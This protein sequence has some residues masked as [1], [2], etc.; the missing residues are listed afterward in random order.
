MTSPAEHIIELQR[1][2]FADSNQPT[3]DSVEAPKPAGE[4][5][6]ALALSKAM[7]STARERLA[8]GKAFA[9]VVQVPTDKWI[10]VT[11]RLI[12]DIGGD[13]TY[14][15]CRRTPATNVED[16]HLADCLNEGRAVVGISP[17]PDSM[18]PRT[19]LALADERISLE[20][21]DEEMVVKA[22]RQRHG[23][24]SSLDGIDVTV[25]EFDELALAIQNSGD[26][27]QAVERL[28]RISESRKK[29]TAAKVLPRLEEALE[30]GKAREWALSLRD[31][32]LAYR[33]KIVGWEHL[34]RGAVFHG[35]PGT[36][37]TLLAQ[38]LGQSC[39]LPTVVTSVAEL[40]ATSNGYLEGVI[41]A[42]RK[43]FA[44]AR[45]MAPAILFLDE[46]NAMPNIDRLDGR[47]K[48]YWATLI[49]DF[50][51]L[52]DGAL[53]GREGVIVIGAT[54][55]IEDI[56]PALL[57]PGRLE[58]S[59]YVG[60]PDSAGIENIMRHHLGPDLQGEDLSALAAIDAARRATGAMVMEQV[61]AARRVA[62]RSVRPL[63]L[64]DL[65]GQV[66]PPDVRTH[67]DRRRV[68]THEAGH[69]IAGLALGFGPLRLV[70]IV[71]TEE[72]GGRTDFGERR[73][74]AFNTRSD[75]EKLAVT[76]LAGRAAEQLLLGEPS[77]GAGGSEDSDL[78]RATKLYSEMIGSMGLGSRLSYRFLQQSITLDREF[79]AEIDHLLEEAHERALRLLDGHRNDLVTLANALLE[80]PYMIGEDVNR[81][82]AKN[83]SVA[84]SG[85]GKAA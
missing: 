59:I 38:M 6:G 17:H 83:E 62:R 84:L 75:I 22:I 28:R 31:D 61:R 24:S 30:Y 76:L 58:R 68:A 78:A 77:G 72:T 43:A 1:L 11:S 44:E 37:K 48:D 55:R 74:T 23:T 51:T 13:D 46:L 35:P 18:L 10:S 14:V 82:L 33:A 29:V 41:K 36:G 79:R 63:A 70:S 5:L 7:G 67:D 53:S 71:E 12:D 40:F 81:L 16:V 45:A 19:L 27:A 9:L 50:Y 85:A 39:G 57:R 66:A 21:P 15:L 26:A 54:N 47:N 64:S 8:S 34:D 80:T 20:L 52:L 2:N 4:I 73:V 25:I 65:A 69:A 32:I 60:P 42:L 3:T 49:L 56:H